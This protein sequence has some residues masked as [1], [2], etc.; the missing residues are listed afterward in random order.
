[1]D[2]P[3]TVL[4]WSLAFLPIALLLF[5]MI[6]RR[7]GAAEAGPLAWIIAAVVAAA[8]FELP[9]PD[10]GLQSVK[11]TWDAITI[12]YV[13][14]PAILIYEVTREADAFEPFRRGITRLLPHPLI[15]VMAF[16]WIFAS[17]LQGITGFG[18]PVAVCAPLLI[19]IGVR[20]LYAVVIPLV[21][22]AW[23]NTFGTLA[24]AWLGLGQVTDM[25]PAV[26]ATTALYAAA[27]VW[28]LNLMGGLLV[29]WLYGK[30]RGILE[31]LPAVLAISLV[32][33][34]LTLVLS[35][36]S[37]VLNGFIAGVVGFAL[38]FVLGR[39]PRYKRTPS[40]TG[41]RIFESGPGH[42]GESLATTEGAP[43]SGGAGRT[44]TDGGAG[45]GATEESTP[46]SEA[47]SAKRMSL[48]R[49]FIPYYALLVITLGIL[50]TPLERLLEV[51]S[52]GPSFPEITT[53]LGFITG[54]EDESVT[55]LTTPGTFLF[56]AAFIGYFA[57]RSMGYIHTGGLRRI[58][59][60]TAGKAI[61]ATIAVVSLVAMAAV[62]QGAGQAEVL[63][64]GI[65]ATTGG[66]YAFLAPFIGVLGAFMTSS[67]LASNLLFGGFQE[68]TAN[69]AGL[70]QSAVLGAQT[71]GGATGNI[72]APGNVIL[73]TTTAGILGR[74]G[75]V[76]RITL[77]LTLLIAAVI[78]VAVLA[79]A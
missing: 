38:I 63:A 61:P 65:A 64:L 41:S 4:N 62:M 39:L 56:A 2:M 43:T 77:P 34:G 54:A 36:W 58:G 7:W 33:G 71:A 55:I 24:V 22:H 31:G 12:L 25:S 27:F 42:V 78:G 32:H 28:I 23:N 72:L 49:A 74:E 9:L 47:A 29:C 70:N 67:N 75:D 6:A 11:G 53:G 13:V 76:L 10:L 40:V 3:V 17:F 14:W 37:D 1:M 30:V 60:N 44:L 57:Y 79:V 19:G 68:S 26:A 16:G 5:M 20:P 51:Y 66:F 59:S 73:G 8:V 35:Q 52:I 15:Q 18:V 69:A 50:L 46:G 45:G 21:G 48:N